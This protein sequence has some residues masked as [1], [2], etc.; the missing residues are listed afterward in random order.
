MKGF[1]V[2]EGEEEE[3][4]N[5]EDQDDDDDDVFILLIFY[6]VNNVIGLEKRQSRVWREWRPTRRR[7]LIAENY[8]IIELLAGVWQVPYQKIVKLGTKPKYCIEKT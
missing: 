8:R 1:V 6:I 2:E 5:E 3:E 7:K 4:G